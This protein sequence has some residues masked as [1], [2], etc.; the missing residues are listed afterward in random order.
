MSISYEQSRDMLQQKHD[1]LISDIRN[2]LADSMQDFDLSLEST[3]DK[4]NLSAGYL[5]KLFKSATGEN[6]SHYLINLRLN[7]AARLLTET[8]IPAKTIC[9]KI[10]MTNV[11]YFSTLFKKHMGLSPIRYREKMQKE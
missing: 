2:Y 3:A 10:G 1:Q 11:T 6:F 5:G 7:E 8:A 9:E 4:F